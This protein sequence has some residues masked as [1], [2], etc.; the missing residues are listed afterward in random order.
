MKIMKNEKEMKGLQVHRQYQDHLKRETRTKN[1]SNKANQILPFLIC[2]LKMY[3]YLVRISKVLIR[4]KIYLH[5]G[6]GFTQT[7]F[8]VMISVCESKS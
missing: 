1:C 3:F 5:Y 8:L 6:P 4:Q 2:F 7:I